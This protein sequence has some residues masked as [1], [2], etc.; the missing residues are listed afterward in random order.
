MNECTEYT[1]T[2]ENGDEAKF[3]KILARL[4]DDE[5]TLIE[6]VRLVDPDNPRYSKKTMVLEMEP[7]SCLTIRLGMKEVTIRRKRSEDELA[8][9]QALIDRQKI[10]IK[11]IVPDNL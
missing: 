10:T 7:E 1:F 6:D 4:D 9:E 11:V 2:F 3:R 8:E 5:Y